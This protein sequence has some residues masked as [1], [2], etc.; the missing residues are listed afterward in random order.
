MTHATVLIP[1]YR[2]AALLPYAVRSALDQRDATVEVFVVGDGVEDDTRVA[3][4][5][6]LA[7]E[8]VRFFDLPKGAR[9]GELNRHHALAEARGEIVCYLSD[10]DVLLPTHVATAAELLADAEF[11]H[12]PPAWLDPTGELHYY[13]WDVGRAEFLELAR[14][15]PGSVG[16]TGTSHT[17]EAYRR[18]PFGWRAAPTNVMTDQHMWRQ[19]FE[20]PGFRGRSGD[21]LT[22]LW[23]PSSLWGGLPVEEREAAL[24]G[25]FARSREPGFE[26]D[27]QELLR[28]A[29]RRAADDF[30]LWAQREE[31]AHAEVRATRTWRLR[32]ALLRV[33][34]LR[35]LLARRRGAR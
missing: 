18:L 2:H 12:G 14:V 24:A 32:E 16:V 7:D 31:L 29:V 6:L 4:E 17:L 8:R 22:H 30:H 28:D 9:H 3:L 19:W 10:D 26:D 13:P 33:R 25:W 34:P 11:C 35:A 20:L 23:F 21:R 5:P 1:T 27:L 15:R